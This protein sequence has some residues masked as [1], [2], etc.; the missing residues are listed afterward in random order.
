MTGKGTEGGSVRALV[1]DL[2]PGVKYQF[3]IRTVSYE[4]QSDVTTLSARTSQYFVCF[5]C[6]EIFVNCL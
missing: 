5:F 2:M 6:K 1:E 4:L 3:D